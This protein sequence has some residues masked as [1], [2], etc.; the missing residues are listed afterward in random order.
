MSPSSNLLPAQSDGL[1][2]RVLLPISLTLAAFLL[3]F[4]WLGRLYLR[5]DITDDLDR[6]F[7]TV[8][9]LQGSLLA[10]RV[11]VMDAILQQIHDDPALQAAMRRGDRQALLQHSDRL[12]RTLL[13]DHRITHFYFIDPDGTVRLRVHRPERH[14]DVIERITLRRAR[15]TGRLAS[16]LELGP[17]GT[18]TLRVVLP[19]E[20]E[21]RLLGFL[22]LGEDITE[23]GHQLADISGAETLVALRRE[24][25]A[26]DLPAADRVAL[27][28]HLVFEESLPGLAQ[29]A[30]A[31]LGDRFPAAGEEINVD[32]GDRRYLGRFLPLADAGERM[33]GHLL[34]FRDVSES[35]AEFRRLQWT[36]VVISL[37]LAGLLLATCYLI[38]GRVQLQL[39]TA[40]RRLLDEIERTRQSNEALQAEVAQRKRAEAALQESHD[41]LE[42]R[43]EERTRD[44]DRQNRLLAG[45][46]ANTPYAVAWK[47]AGEVYAGCNPVFAELLA[48]P[49][50]TIVGRSDAALPWPG[51]LRLILAKCEEGMRRDGLPVVDREASFPVAGEAHFALVSLL[52]L[53][54]LGGREEGRLLIIKDFTERKRQELRLRGAL[55]AT[56]RARDQ[57]AGILAAVDAPLLVTDLQ[58]RLL[59]TNAGGRGLLGLSGEFETEVGLPLEAVVGDPQLLAALRRALAASEATARFD[60]APPQ[61]ARLPAPP[62]YVVNAA[63]VGGEGE[64]S[65]M[66]FLFR[67]VTDERLMDRLKSDFISTA[68]HE[69]RTPVATILGYS[70]LLAEHEGFSG[71]E[72]REFVELIARK[73]VSLDE[74]LDDLLDLSRIESGRALELRRQPMAVD[75]LLCPA[76]DELRRAYPGRELSCEVAD[77]G[78][79]VEV[80]RNRMRQVLEN[81]VGNAVKYS[82]AGGPVRVTGERE[83]GRYR[84]TVADEGMGMSA[85]QVRRAFEKFYRGDNTDT[86]I[87][88]TGLGLT[89]V[90]S[91]VAAHG[92]KVWIESERGRGTRVRF[93]LPLVEGA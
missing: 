29:A 27:A 22:E 79:V 10:Q 51:D 91:I 86:A 75:D 34:V 37:L 3:V 7:R 48:L 42:R 41:L 73:A 24:V 50:E 16:G 72:R 1:R 4:F 11:E 82:P 71:E 76:L 77:G 30:A 33:V 43:V 23:L 63:A 88:G 85:E 39:D 62:V 84:V 40:R 21:G 32:F 52:P 65:G 70:E 46:I 57:I 6:Q 25:L 59:L 87:P 93:T 89:I 28:D 60:Y 83:D 44:L 5:H 26:A 35:I 8:E 80:D 69:L 36:G 17:L 2:R 54:A 45:L 18:F 81:L 19:W 31:A 47:E 53:P 56:A 55:E 58:G 68:A 20:V 61:A 67:D 78:S 90:E 92:G 12:Y 14:G 9:Q 64:R 38:L 13:H 74:L 66:L 15:A 49:P